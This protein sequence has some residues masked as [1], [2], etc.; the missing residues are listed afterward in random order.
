MTTT[1]PQS[2]KSAMTGAQQ[3][4]NSIAALLNDP[5]VKAQMATAL[6][7]HMTADRLARIALTEVR[8]NKAL[9]QCD[10][11]S[12]LGA[13]MMCA[14]LGL[15]PGGALGHV[16]LV[17][18]RN[19][20]RGSMDVQVIIGYRGMIELARRSGQIQSIEARAVYEGDVFEVELGLNSN[21]RHVPDFD[22]PNRSNPEKLRFVY[23]VAHLKDGGVQF[24]V[25]SR[26]EI[27]TVRAASKSGNSNKSPWVTHFEQMALKTVVRRLF[28][29]L[30]ISI[31]L[32][33]AIEQDT[34]A[35]LGLRQ[36]NPLEDEPA[37]FDAET[38]EMIDGGEPRAE[39]TAKG[40]A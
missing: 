12:F 24:E 8:T 18:F 34:R 4:S 39:E 22:N 7:K 27:E 30:P 17:P 2:L 33:H 16:Y 25:M 26:K 32:A 15:E 35:E 19:N 13:I 38:G 3:K 23:A 10:Q 1:T 5:K 14:Q 29:W 40:N 21:L 6:P 20:E 28:K 31:E 11:R 37:T 9:A 36:D